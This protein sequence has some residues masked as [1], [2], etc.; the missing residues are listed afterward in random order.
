MGK[1]EKMLATKH[2]DISWNLETHTVARDYPLLTSTHVQYTHT[3]FKIILFKQIN[4]IL[5]DSMGKFCI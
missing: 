4:A 1:W 3:H 5:K 2:D